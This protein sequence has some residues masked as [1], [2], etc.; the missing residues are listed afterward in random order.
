MGLNHALAV[1]HIREN[2]DPDAYQ[3]AHDNF[4]EDWEPVYKELLAAR[5][6]LTTAARRLLVKIMGVED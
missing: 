3:A 5:I 6:E 1:S 2:F 4:K